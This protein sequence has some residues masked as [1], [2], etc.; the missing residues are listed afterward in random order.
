MLDAP[1][2]SSLLENAG[3]FT[4]TTVNTHIGQVAG[5]SHLYFLSWINTEYLSQNHRHRMND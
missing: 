3:F 2:W 5:F 1:W 4:L